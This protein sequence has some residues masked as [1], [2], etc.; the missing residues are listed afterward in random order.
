MLADISTEIHAKMRVLKGEM[1]DL[2]NGG[3]QGAAANGFAQGWDHW[4][5]GANDVLTALRT[6]GRLLGTTGQDYST[7]DEVSTNQLHRS[8]EGL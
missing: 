5:A 4:Q 3:W 7:L 2:L 1:D 8:G 6:M